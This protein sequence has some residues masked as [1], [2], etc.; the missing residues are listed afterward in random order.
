MLHSYL[1]GMAKDDN[2]ENDGGPSIKDDQDVD[3]EEEKEEEDDNEV[4]EEAENGK[5][6]D[7]MTRREEDDDDAG[8]WS[9]PLLATAAMAL[10][11]GDGLKASEE[12]TGIVDNV[13]DNRSG[14]PKP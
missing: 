14:S 2:K 3:E 9:K 7:R 1:D 6:W 11:M 8:P 5:R 10:P 12:V 13:D 4:E